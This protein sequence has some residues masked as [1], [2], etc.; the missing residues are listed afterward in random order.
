LSS[1]WVAATPRCHP[2]LC[3]AR[4]AAPNVVP[5]WSSCCELDGIAAHFAAASTLLHASRQ[6]QL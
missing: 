1:G 3:S 2:Y 4:R 6:A 5:V